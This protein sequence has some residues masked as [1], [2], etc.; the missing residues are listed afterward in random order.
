MWNVCI[1]K[2]KRARN[3]INKGRSKLTYINDGINKTKDS[4]QTHFELGTR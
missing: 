3:A 4:L 1:N 2:V